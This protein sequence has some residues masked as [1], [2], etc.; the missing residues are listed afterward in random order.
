MN[1]V[2]NDQWFEWSKNYGLLKLNKLIGSN[3]FAPKWR[4]AHVVCYVCM[5]AA[6]ILSYSEYDSDFPNLLPW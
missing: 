2:D 6:A 1:D 4:L 3:I 5:C